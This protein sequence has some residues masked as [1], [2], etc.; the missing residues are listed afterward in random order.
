MNKWRTDCI[1]L[2]TASVVHHIINKTCKLLHVTSVIVRKKMSSQ[3]LERVHQ[4]VFKIKHNNVK[5]K[6]TLKGKVRHANNTHNVWL[7]VLEYVIYLTDLC[8]LPKMT[9]WTLIRSSNIR[10]STKTLQRAWRNSWKKLIHRVLTGL[11]IILHTQSV[12]ISILYHSWHYLQVRRQNM[13]KLVMTMM[14]MMIIIMIKTK[15]RKTKLWWLTALITV[16]VCKVCKKEL[17]AWVQKIEGRNNKILQIL[18]LLLLKVI[19]MIICILNHQL[20]ISHRYTQS[21]MMPHKTMK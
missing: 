14:I 13:A 7:I 12:V 17:I 19:I 1:N 18:L 11:G 9:Y 8:I 4:E 5:Y 21:R 15:W 16:I 2:Q 20:H 3:V 10:V 6:H